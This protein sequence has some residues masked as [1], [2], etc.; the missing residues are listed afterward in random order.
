[1]NLAIICKVLPLAVCFEHCLVATPR[2]IWALSDQPL[3]SSQRS[4]RLVFR[5]ARM[6]LCTAWRMH[7]LCAGCSATLALLLSASLCSLD[8]RTLA[9]SSP[10]MTLPACAKGGGDGEAPYPPSSM[11]GESVPPILAMTSAP[12]QAHNQL[13]PDLGSGH[14]LSGGPKALRPPSRSC[15]IHCPIH[16]AFG[17]ALTYRSLLA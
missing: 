14:H 5:T 17:E 13:P 8:L 15:T 10:L 12:H 1:M 11:T 4:A 9:S 16:E 2:P 3:V 7:T 6:L